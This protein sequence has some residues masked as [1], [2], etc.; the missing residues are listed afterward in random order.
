M[1]YMFSWNRGKSTIVLPLKIDSS[2]S[3]NGKN[4]GTLICN[5]CHSPLRQVYRCEHTVLD[6]NGKPMFD[7]EGKPITNGCGNE[8]TIRDIENRLDS[9]EGVIYKVADKNAF[10]KAKVENKITVIKEVNSTD[11]LLHAELLK[12]FKELHTDADG[13]AIVT[14]KKVHEWLSRHNKALLVRFGYRGKVSGGVIIAARNKLVIAELRDYR[15]VKAPKHSDITEIPNENTEVF[16]TTS[17]DKSNDDYFEFIEL[18][19]AGKE[20]PSKVQV[21]EAK[22]TAEIPSF[23]DD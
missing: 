6:A 5:E 22:A 13:T 20:I 21:E 12:S 1:P 7:N 16:N 10:M 18:V 4:S 8:Y 15:L 11:I 9:E 23:L 14:L 2:T 19:K 3:S 17:I